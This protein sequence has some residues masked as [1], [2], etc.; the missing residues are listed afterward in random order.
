MKFVAQGVQKLEPE[1]TETQTDSDRQTDVAENITV[2]LSWLVNMNKPVK[3][4]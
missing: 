2:P 4:K 3:F 1:Q